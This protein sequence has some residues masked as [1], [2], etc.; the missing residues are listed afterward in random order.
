[1]SASKQQLVAPFPWFGGKSRVADIVW[2]RFGDVPNY[3]E[4][5]AGSLAVLLGRPRAH[6]ARIETANDLDGFIANFWRAIAA[7]PQATA[8]AADWP[9]NENDKHARHVWLVGQR[10]SL[11]RRLEGDPDFYDAKIA[12]WWAWGVCMWIGGGFC[13]GT[14]PWVS[15]DGELVKVKG[16]D[17]PGVTL[18]IPSLT[19][20]NGRGLLSVTQAGVSR[21]LPHLGDAGQGVHKAS[22]S[23]Q[24][25]SLGS[26]RGVLRKDTVD[27][28]GLYSWFDRLSTRLRR[29]RVCSGDWE[30]V[31]ADSVTTRHGMTGLFLDPPYGGEVDQSRVYA[32]DS[33]TVSDD[34]R[35]WCLEHGGDP[36][37]RIA[38]CGYEGEGH[39]ALLEAGWTAH[40]WASNGYGHVEGAG[41]SNRLKER[42]Y[43]SP[44]CLDPAADWVTGAFS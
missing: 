44:A 1:V 6:E 25:P 21:Q 23:R 14:G 24:L 5:F 8:A 43:F 37:L 12:G 31:V 18:D 39:E 26:D 15:I 33:T 17:D 34:V 16:G 4:P 36:L 41:G 28:G 29:V 22:I 2:D 3:V 35:A 11:Q 9:I 10:E 7:D 32:A 42:I 27:T 20:A 38:L 13:S 19:T 30:R 40:A